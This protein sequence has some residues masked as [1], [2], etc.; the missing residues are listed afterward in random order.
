MFSNG[1]SHSKARRGTQARLS[2][3][4]TALP[5]MFLH[6]HSPRRFPSRRSTAIDRHAVRQSQIKKKSDLQ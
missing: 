6:I 1:K 3:A 4:Q 5:Q 2:Q